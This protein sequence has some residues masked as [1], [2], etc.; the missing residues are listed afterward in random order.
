M[1]GVIIIGAKDLEKVLE[2]LERYDAK[3]H[4]REIK[5]IK[6]DKEKLKIS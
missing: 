4:F 5:L 6:E 2:F 3:V 1:R